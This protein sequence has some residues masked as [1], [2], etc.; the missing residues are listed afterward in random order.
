MTH[1]GELA[2]KRARKHVGEELERHG[3]QELH[4]GDN[5][6][7]GKRDKAQK[8]GSSAAELAC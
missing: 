7:D 2:L 3:E 6:E 1:L 5:D 4:K 8:I